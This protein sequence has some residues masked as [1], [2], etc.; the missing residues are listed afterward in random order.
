MKLCNN[1]CIRIAIIL[2]VFLF[3]ACAAFQ[4]MRMTPE[5]ALTK[6]VT[7]YWDARVQGDTETA[8]ELLEPKAKKITPLATY[9][10]RTNHSVILDYT[11]HE[12]NVD[13]ENNE[14]V[15]RVERSFR[16]KPGIIPIT[17]DE[18]LKQDSET[19]WVLVDGTW[20]RSYDS[21]GLNFMTSPVK[22]ARERKE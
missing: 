10:R 6:R 17:V 8:Y 9:A 2:F 1:N 4:R 18:T 13:P 16:I 20:Y 14:A 22:P 12:I 5:E 19:P 7:E 3:S 21:P 15:V 11:I